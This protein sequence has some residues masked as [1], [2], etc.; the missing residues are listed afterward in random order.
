MF[1]PLILAGIGYILFD[2]FS[3]KNPAK[4][5]DSNELETLPRVRGDDNRGDG[6]RESG[7]STPDN[8]ERKLD[9]EPEP[10]IDPKPAPVK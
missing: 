10:K 5:G 9:T 7:A 8:R 1:H 3:G 6:H 4:K 2:I